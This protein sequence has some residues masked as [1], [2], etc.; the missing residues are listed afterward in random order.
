[1]DEQMHRS[2]HTAPGTTT[3]SSLRTMSG[4][5]IR[6]NG[7]LGKPLRIL[8]VEDEAMISMLTAENLRDLGFEVEDAANAASA[9]DAAKKNIGA[10]A[11]AIIDIGLPDRKGDDLAI[12]LKG[13]RP[14]LPIVIATGQG[15]KALDGKLNKTRNLTLLKKPY[16]S[17]GLKKSLQTLGVSAKA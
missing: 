12:E 1:M 4:K 3:E 13:L 8:L 17:D 7:T 5:D 11:A 10:F 15:D 2:L 14:D 9:I 6:P 16:D